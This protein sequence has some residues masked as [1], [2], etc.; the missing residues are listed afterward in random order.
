VWITED[1]VFDKIKQKDVE[2][3]KAED[4]KAAKQLEKARKK[5]KK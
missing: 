5:K 4:E 3:R 1:K 2:K